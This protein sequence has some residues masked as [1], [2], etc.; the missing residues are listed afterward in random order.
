MTCADTGPAGEN[1]GAASF[2]GGAEGV[3]AQSGPHA[4]EAP[5][6]LRHVR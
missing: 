6:R 1:R 4:A 3:G 2:R 5:P